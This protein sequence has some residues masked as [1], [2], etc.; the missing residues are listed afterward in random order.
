MARLGKPGGM[1]ESEGVSMLETDCLLCVLKARR[2][3]SIEDEEG[4]R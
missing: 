4:E 3:S 2:V 1:V